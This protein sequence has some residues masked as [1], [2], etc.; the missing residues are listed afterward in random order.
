MDILASL[1]PLEE[2]LL[3]ASKIDLLQTETWRRREC[4]DWLC[5]AETIIKILAWS[6]W[7]Y[8]KLSQLD[9]KVEKYT[10]FSVSRTLEMHPCH[11]WMD[12]ASKKFSKKVDGKLEL[13]KSLY[14]VFTLHFLGS[15][16]D[17]D[18]KSALWFKAPGRYSTVI[19]VHFNRKQFLGQNIVDK[20]T[21]LSNT[22]FS[23][24][25]LQLTFRTFVAQMSKFVIWVDGRV[26]AHQ[27]K[28]SQGFF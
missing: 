20:S 21:K 12:P 23:M 18:W 3:K 22:I 16:I 7:T 17:H 8:S 10:S 15:F 9:W 28:A 2:P 4:Q 1:R 13:Q 26:L 27:F 24:E 11:C 5:Q 19:L 6:N 25:C 14:L